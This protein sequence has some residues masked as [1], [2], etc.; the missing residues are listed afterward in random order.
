MARA[1]QRWF[2]V[3][4]LR[5]DLAA[6]ASDSDRVEKP[7]A[8][9]VVRFS[10][11]RAR[12]VLAAKRTEATP[13]SMSLDLL[14]KQGYFAE[15]VEQTGI[16]IPGI[17]HSITRDLLGF[18]DILAMLDHVLLVQTTSQTNVAARVK[19]IQRCE[20][21]EACKRAGVRVHVH[22]WGLGGLVVIDMTARAE[23]G[24]WVHRTLFDD[25]VRAG[26]KSKLKPRLQTLLR[27]D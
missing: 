16:R 10:R 22:G 21:F 7:E 8:L 26:V 1:T 4:R 14:R 9:S 24:S 3:D 17:P 23:D 12:R 11:S 25:I 6:V 19:K 5:P 13:M 18:A 20:S 15:S 2:R 27:L